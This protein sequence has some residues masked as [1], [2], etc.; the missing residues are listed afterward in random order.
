MRTL[1][2]SSLKAWGIATVAVFAL[3]LHAPSAHADSLLSLTSF[4]VL[5]NNSGVGDSLANQ[6]RVEV[7]DIGGGQVQFEFFN[8]GSIESFVTDIYF[9]DSAL[10]NFSDPNNNLIGS[11]TISN[12]GW[13]W[14]AA[15][16]NLP[17]GSSVGFFTASTGGSADSDPP[18]SRNGIDNTINEDIYF[19]IDLGSGWGFN[20]VTSSLLSGDLRLGIRVQ[21]IGT[22]D[23]SDS[24]I[25]TAVVPLPSGAGMALAGAA[26]LALWGRHKRQQ[27]D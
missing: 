27:R 16:P 3:A 7:S 13:S 4:V 1:S 21:G 14:D 11:N 12:V 22:E 2:R 26:V 25:T 6:F 10:L 8:T 23:F 18:V 17:G 24:Y 15:P 19:Q 9:E 20:D 5:E